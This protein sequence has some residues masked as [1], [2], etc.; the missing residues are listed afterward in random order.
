[1][2]TVKMNYCLYLSPTC[3]GGESNALEILD[4]LMRDTNW[5]INFEKPKTNPASLSP[6]TSI[7][8]PHMKFG[9]LSARKFYW[10]LH[11]VYQRVRQ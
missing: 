3:A 5:I 11:K 10:E 2:L 6:S 8:S 1:M 7:L 4:Q 9:C